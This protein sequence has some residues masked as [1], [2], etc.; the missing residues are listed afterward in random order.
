MRLPSLKDAL[1]DVPD[2]RQAQGR[3]YD[4]LPVLLLCCVA[5]MCGARSQSAIAEWGQNYGVRWLKRL[6]IRRP[7]GPSQPTLHHILTGLDCAR[8]EQCVTGWAERVLAARAAPAAALEGLALD[9]KT[10]RGSAQQGAAES[11]L[12]SALSH[13]LGVVMAQLAVPDKSHELGHL[14]PL[15]AALV[16]EG[17]VITCDA[18]HTHRDVARAIA[19]RGGDYL[20][21]V[22][23]NQRVLRSDIALVFA[24]RKELADTISRAQT[25]DSHGDRIE[26]RRLCAST[27]L[28]G[29]VEWPGH[30][31]VLELRRQ[32][33]NKRTAEPDLDRHRRRP[34]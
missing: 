6:G 15:L 1:A 33:T 2:F 28:Q 20:L 10:L 23:E 31:Q 30:A 4:L 9:G 7:R 12:V 32:V 19:D 8:F 29:Y 26:V 5:V 14:E 16:L 17:R 21:P 25:T 18:L 22:K 11:H 34:R 24:H 3:R 27:A 13:R